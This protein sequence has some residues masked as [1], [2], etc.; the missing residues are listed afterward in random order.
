MTGCDTCVVRNRAICAGLG[1]DELAVLSQMGRQRTLDAGEPLI[2][3]GDESVLVANVIEGVLKLSS[4][5]EDGREQIVGVVYPS[6]FIGR[7]FAGAAGHSV[8]ALT[9]AR[10]CVFAR[11][12]FDRFASEHPKLEHKLLERTLGELDRTRKWMVLLSRKTAQEKVATFLLEMSDR[13]AESGCEMPTGTSLKAF[14]LPFSRQQIADV[15]GLTI[16]TVSRQMTTLKRDGII[17][18][19]TRRSVEIIDRTTLEDIAGG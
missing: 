7:P 8:T 16:E 9:E 3:E 10:V 12:D 17:G 18:L 4:S 1:S 5:T 14:D 2:W 13:L 11:K 6:D 19:P 15:L